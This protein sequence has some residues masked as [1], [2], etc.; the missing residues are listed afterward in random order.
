MAPNAQREAPPAL[1]DCAVGSFFRLR[2]EIGM[3]WHRSLRL[4][5]I[6][7]TMLLAAAGAARASKITSPPNDYDPSCGDYPFYSYIPACTPNASDPEGAAGMSIDKAWKRFTA[8]N[9]HTVI[10]YVEAAIN[11]HNG[12]APELADR[13]FLNRGELPPPT[14]PKDDGVLNARDYHDTPDYNGNGVVDPEDIIKRFSDGVDDDHNG[15]TDDISGWDFYDNQNDPATVDSSYGHANGQ[16]KRAA[17]QANNGQGGVGECPRCMILPIKAGAEALDR[18][19]DLAEAWLYASDMK[20]DVIVSVTADLGYSTFMK[21]AIEHIWR[22]NHTVM[23]ESSNDFDSTD[24]QGGMFHAHVLPGNGLVKDTSGYPDPPGNNATTTYRARSGLTSWGTHNYFSGETYGGSTSESSP[25]IGGVMALVLAYGKEAAGQGKIARPLTA[26]EALQVVRATASDVNDPNSN[27]PSKPGFD[28]QFGY[29]RPNVFKAMKAISRGRIPPVGWI[30]SPDWYALYDPTRTHSV[31]V[32]GHVAAPRSSR[33]HW[34]LEFAPG[35]EP[36]SGDFM[37][38][39]HGSGSGGFSGKLGTIDL[40]KVPQTFWKAAFALSTDKQLSTNEQYTVTIRLRVFDAN[41]RMAEDRR[42]IAVHHDPSLRRHFPKLIGPGGESQPQ[43]GDLQ[44][45]G[46]MAIVFGDA[47]GVVHAIDG[48]TGRELPGWPVTTN[49]TRVTKQHRGVNPGHE[50]VLNNVAIGDLDHDGHLE[51]VATSTTG[52]VYVWNERGRRRPGWPKALRRGVHKPPIPRPAMAHARLPVQGA[53]AP[54]VLYDLNGDRSLEIVQAAWDGH[55]YVW[56]PNGRFLS[57]WPK[58]V[59]LPDGFTPASGH[60]VVNDQKLDLPPAIGDIDGDG[61]PDLVVRSQ[62]NEVTG[63]GLQPD[64]I[65][66]L[67]AYH[68]NG[69]PVAGFP[70]SF[71][72][73]VGYYGSAQEF[74]TEGTDAPTLADAIPGDGGALEIANSPGIFSPTYLFDGDGSQLDVYGPVPADTLGLFTGQTSILSVLGPNPPTDA[75]VTFTGSGAFGRFGTSNTLAFVQPG[76]GGASTIAGLLLAGSGS[77]IKSSLRAYDAASA[78][79]LPGF[80]SATQ[81]LDFLGAAVIGDVDGDGKPDLIEGGDSSALHAFAE[82]GGQASGFPKFQTGWVVFGPSIGDVNSDGRN[83]VAAMT[84]EGYLMVWRTNGLA[85]ANDEWWSYRHDERNTAQ[86]GIDTRPP[87]AIRRSRLVSGG[88]KLNFRAPGDDWYTGKPKRYRLTFYRND[89]TVLS[90]SRIAATV[91]AGG[92]ETID[93]PL[94]AARVR[95]VAV[96]DA[97]N[98]GR[99]FSRR[100]PLAAH[101]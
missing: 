92:T 99:P 71:H 81:G 1:A 2:G 86:Y 21:E 3:S 51:V 14:T 32:R 33:F 100:V 84:R 24:H 82:G 19:D 11:W 95:I 64:E 58:K 60:A 12:D 76:S 8:G 23:V 44:G 17:G 38:A 5:L 57:G 43:L 93:R 26:D 7:A 46:H 59:K 63:D 101:G 73:I 50:P 35:A 91:S 42:T 96:D 28:L 74:I 30:N 75:P 78:S 89:G 13:V 54:P 79:D 36:D 88:S 80:P 53:V 25:T 47:D 68:A 87:G 4:T 9:G 66:H 72:A 65:S 39:G 18:T 62:Y 22:G 83:D 77:P 52:N 98:L 29:G 69:T 41:G 16:M 6:A 40:S 27:W 90:R 48:R 56:K 31:P 55:L 10:A 61:K 20:A 45:R 15:Y 97:G 37:N 49:R 94:H 85:T 67:N 34:R 70:N